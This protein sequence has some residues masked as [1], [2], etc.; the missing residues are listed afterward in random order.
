MKTEIIKY[1][2]KNLWARKSRT[3]LTALS[4]VIGVAAVFIFASFGVGLYSYVDSI[5][6]ETG[7]DLFWVNTKGG[8]AP[9]LDTTFKL[10]D[11]DLETVERIKGVS[12]ATG[13]YVKVAEVEKD[14]VKKYIF[15]MGQS[16][17]NEDVELVESIMTV[18]IHAGRQFKSIAWI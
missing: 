5:A 2:L 14:R 8:A 12:T 11:K 15:M 9:G 1:A 3:F 17:D 4:I 18:K 6:Q 13:L 10:E 7:V 16:D